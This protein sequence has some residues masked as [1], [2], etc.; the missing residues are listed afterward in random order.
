MDMLKFCAKCKKENEETFHGYI[1]WVDEDCYECP[2]CQNSMTDTILTVDEYNI[3]DNISGDISFLEA[4]IKLKQDDIIE[5]QSRI[6]QFKLQQD[7]AENIKRHKREEQSESLT[8][9]KCGSASIIEG[10][11]GFSI[12]TGFIGSGKFRYVCKN[13][14]NKWKP[15]S[16]LET[17]QR[18]NNKN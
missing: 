1:G 9:P 16:I 13:C 7:Q 8:C 5:F 11:K 17:L 15:G 6:N 18:V 10:T 3:I 2:I 4:M 12:M 14:G